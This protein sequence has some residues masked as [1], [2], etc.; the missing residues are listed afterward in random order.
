MILNIM[1]IGEKTAIYPLQVL[2]NYWETK[3][4]RLGAELNRLMRQ[5]IRHVASFVPW[6]SAE[7][8]ITHKLYKFLQAIS[9]RKMTVTLIVSPEVGVYFQNSG[10]P[11]DLVTKPDMLARCRREKPILQAMAPNFYALPSLH[12]SDVVKRYHQFLTRMDGVIGE[13]LKATPDLANRVQI[14]MSGGFWKYYRPASESALSTFGGVTGDHSNAAE[15]ALRH[16]VDQAYAG[17]EF[18]GQPKWKSREME[19]INRQ[20]FAQNAEDLFRVRSAAFFKRKCSRLPFLHGEVFTPEAD[21]AYLYSQSMQMATQG[22]ADFSTLDRL[23]EDSAYRKTFAFDQSTTPLIHWTGF[24]SFSE[25]SDSEKQFLLLKSTFLV[26][27]RGGSVILDEREWLRLSPNFR[28][29]VELFSQSIFEGALSLDTRALTITSHVWSEPKEMVFWPEMKREIGNH[30][31]IAAS[32]DGLD[33]MENASLILIEPNY[34]LSQDRLRRVRALVEKGK[35]I[36]L[37]MKNPMTDV[38]RDELTKFMSVAPT[39]N[40][41][42]GTRYSIH[43][44]GDGKLIVYEPCD[45]A[46]NWKKFIVS[47]IQ[48]ANAAPD[49]TVSDSRVQVVQLNRG[50]GMAGIFLFNGMRSNVASEI[51]FQ[52]E[53]TLS[54]L[55]TILTTRT[56]SVGGIEGNAAAD[57]A[58]FELDV[59]PCGVLPIAVSGL[60]EEGQEKIAARRMEEISRKSADSAAFNELPGMD[61]KQDFGSLMQ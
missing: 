7:S 8:D 32:L 1:G 2:V 39:L 30:A 48:L 5:G 51:R 29:R 25:L 42:I 45:D 4:A 24:G 33:E 57:S 16:F 15:V 9:D 31:Q 6:Q 23:V 61:S 53:V 59:P 37:S 43:S 55:A 34:V 26:G 40:L 54:D 44:A 47:M 41:S 50:P 58:Q 46:R 38:V 60:G 18:K 49:A 10:L 11:K 19:A 3:P 36:V 21:P 52:H 20:C 13:A 14:V 28:S 27:A 17:R 56:D 12:N 35:I 22:L